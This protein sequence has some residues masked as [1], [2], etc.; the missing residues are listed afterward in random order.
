MTP[1]DRNALDRHELILVEAAVVERLRRESGVALHPTLVNAPLVH[2]APGRAA[3]ARIYGE[4]LAIAAAAELPMLILTPTWR[5]NRERIGAAGELRDLNGD[6]VRF[7]RGLRARRGAGAP[8]WIGG[9][10]GCRNDC[11]RPDEGLSAAASERF[12]AWQVERLAAAEPDFL[13][14]ATL[15]AV[16][17]ATGI[18]RAM[19]RSGLPYLLSFIIGRD[20]RVLDGT[21][22]VDAVAAIDA[23]VDAPPLGYLINCSYPTFLDGAAPPELS[24]RLIGFQ[25]NAAALDQ[26]ALDG[27]CALRA[28]P[29]A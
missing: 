3:M 13:L 11:Y 21:A 25:A 29:V 18:A 27:A 10:L 2:E 23:A 5:A 15:P 1:L 17:E 28:E 19:A 12:H 8:I 24:R 14:A 7:L 6:G 9:Q 22:L 16:A 4:Y 20:G 26:A